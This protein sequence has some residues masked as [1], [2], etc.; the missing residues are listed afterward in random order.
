MLL[1]SQFD[2]QT[3]TYV[4]KKLSQRWHVFVDGT[5]VQR[6]LYSVFLLLCALT[7]LSAPDLELCLEYFDDL[8]VFHDEFMD[9]HNNRKSHICNIGPKPNAKAEVC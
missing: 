2:H 5:M 9:H 7:R 3:N 6:A 4:K 8:K 1:S